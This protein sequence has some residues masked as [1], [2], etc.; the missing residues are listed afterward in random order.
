[1]KISIEIECNN[2]AFEENGLAAELS[3]I[4]SKIVD[5]AQYNE[6]LVLRDSNGNVVGSFKKQGGGVC[7]TT[8]LGKRHLLLNRRFCKCRRGL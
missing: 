4:F 2:A 6:S 1:M 5:K 3:M 7:Y 8:L